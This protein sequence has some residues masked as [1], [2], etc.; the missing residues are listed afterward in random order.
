MTERAPIA[1]SS[2]A[3]EVRTGFAVDSTGQAV[4]EH[5]PVLDIA[6]APTE[7]REAFSTDG[8][9]VTTEQTRTVGDDFE[10]QHRALIAAH[11]ERS[12]A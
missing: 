4:E 2:D 7:Y 9:G 1:T 10:E 12:E 6:Q 8:N 3:T 11:K 5:T